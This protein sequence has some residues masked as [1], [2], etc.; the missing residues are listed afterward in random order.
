M[1]GAICPSEYHILSIICTI[2]NSTWRTGGRGVVRWQTRPSGRDDPKPGTTISV[3]LVAGREGQ[4]KW[5]DTICE[6]ISPTSTSCTWAKIPDYLTTLSAYSIRINYQNAKKGSDKPADYDYSSPFTINGDKK[7]SLDELP[8]RPA[9]TWCVGNCKDVEAGRVGLSNPNQLP[10]GS[11]GPE[12][13]KTKG[14]T[15]FITVVMMTTLFAL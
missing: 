11:G 4:L 10:Q 1:R 7:G 9:P 5:V 14:T 12:Q 3:E 8:R 2:H 6:N 15:G 13:I